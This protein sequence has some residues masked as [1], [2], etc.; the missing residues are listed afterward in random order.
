MIL[1]IS[2]FRPKSNCHMLFRFKLVNY[3][4]LANWNFLS[5]ELFYMREELKKSTQSIFLLKHTFNRVRMSK[6]SAW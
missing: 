4:I 1:G 6:I 2:I 3:T 5:S